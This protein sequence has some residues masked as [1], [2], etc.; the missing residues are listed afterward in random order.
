MTEQQ[1]ELMK[2]TLQI[3]VPIAMGTIIL[4]FLAS[5]CGSTTTTTTT[6]TTTPPPTTTTT[7]PPPTTTTTTPPTT[8]GVTYQTLASAG[9][10]NYSSICAVCHGSNGGG[11]DICPVVMWGPGTDLGTYN[12]VTLFTD[13]AGMLNYMSKSMPLTAPGSL[14]SQQYMDLLAYILMQANKVSGSTVF[15]QSQLSGISIP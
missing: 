13:A 2:K 9:Q 1:R 14:T 8:T 5:G 12:G 11:T 7:T 3:A 4:V 15:D 6:T 10:S